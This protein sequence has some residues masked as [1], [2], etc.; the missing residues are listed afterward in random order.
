MSEILHPTL[1][2][3]GALSFVWHGNMQ[4]LVPVKRETGKPLTTGAPQAAS[5]MEACRVKV[6]KL[7]S[8]GDPLSS[9]S[10]VLSMVSVASEVL[11]RIGIH[12]WA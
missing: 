8:G 3:V 9:L 12:F 1:A 5:W 11:G 2:L 4:P 6:F 7:E 10:Y